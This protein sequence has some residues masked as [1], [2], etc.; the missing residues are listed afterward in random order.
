[1]VT[2]MVV[3]F[4]YLVVLIDS[5]ILCCTYV[6]WLKWLY[7]TTDSTMCGFVPGIRLKACKIGDPLHSP[8]AHTYCIFFKIRLLSNCELS[9]SVN[10]G[11]YVMIILHGFLSFFPPFFGPY[12]AMIRLS[13]VCAFRSYMWQCL[14]DYMVCWGLNVGGY[15]QGK[16]HCAVSLVPDFLFNVFN[17]V[18]SLMNP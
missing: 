6:L 12:P 5:C 17:C 1:M 2:Y 7:C 9:I 15:V 18:C 8:Q 10:L 16:S 11:Q 4:T 3:V 14:G 13:P